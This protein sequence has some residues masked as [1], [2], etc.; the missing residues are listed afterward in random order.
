M[1]RYT[2]GGSGCSSCG[3]GGGDN[4]TSITD[5]N[6]NVTSY[7]YDALGRVVKETDALGVSI[8][9]TYDSKGNLKTKTDGNGN[10][11]LY[12]YDYPSRLIKKTYPDGSVEA[13]EYD[14]KGNLTYAGNQYEA[15]SL[16]YDATGR[17]KS[18][19]DSDGRVI[20]YAYDMSGNKTKMIG[21]VGTMTYK[22]DS[23]RLS[24]MVSE[25]GTFSFAYD[26]SGRRTKLSYPNGAYATYAYDGSGR[27]T[28]L[29]HKSSSGS[30]ID[31]F[32]YTHDKVGNRLTKA[33]PDRT[34]SYKYDRVYQLLEAVSSTPGW[35][36]NSKTKGSTNPLQNQ[37]EF[38]SYDP[39][40]NRLFGPDKND[41]YSYNQGNQLVSSSEAQFE[42]DLNGNMITKVNVDGGITSYSYDYE[43][44]LTRVIMPDGTTSVYTYDPFGRRI[45]KSVNGTA[46]YYFYDNEDILFEY[47]ATGV[48]G[49]RYAHGLGIDEPLALITEKG[50]Y[51]Y[52]ADGL[53][54]ITSLTDSASKAVQTYEYD[55]FGKL[56]DLK[57]RIKQPYTFT[58][59]EWDRETGTYYFRARTLDPVAGR[60]TQKDPIGFSG[61]V[62]NYVYVKDR[63]TV[64]IDPWGLQMAQS[65]PYVV[66]PAL[67]VI[68]PLIANPATIATAVGVA[69]I[70]WPSELHDEDMLPMPP[71]NPDDLI[72]T[73]EV[74][75]EPMPTPDL[76]NTPEACR[77]KYEQ[78]KMSAD[79]AECGEVSR[80]AKKAWCWTKFLVCLAGAA[81]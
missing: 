42:Y 13:F 45:S 67:P 74:S 64:F 26:T 37:K 2:Y 73:I 18:V 44:R 1:T 15:Y 48:I 21:P 68:A 80:A 12:E 27:L 40:G 76:S 28:S 56:K 3:G 9:Y 55:S 6:G 58:G 33:M 46:T 30:I 14:R 38:Y 66:V 53:G 17:V 78:C 72:P 29:I 54:S 10:V 32:S 59:R 50:V 71:Y 34:T 31:S 4:L 23:G 47:D 75:S 39:V 57:N 25:A 61:G 69:V 62:N 7:K 63:P 51:F 24:Q 65:V 36:A 35:S 16:A 52:H 77:I 81:Q 60:F 79:I 20:T 19:T 5:A 49:N 41:L 11:I 22:Y 43:N 70:L 8:V